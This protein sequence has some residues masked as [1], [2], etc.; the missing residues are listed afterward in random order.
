MTSPE[1]AQYIDT[2]AKRIEFLE[3][4]L[5]KLEKNFNSLFGVVK[6]LSKQNE[7]TT[8]ILVTMTGMLTKE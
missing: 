2:L 5:A 8:G 4:N 3:K 6:L 1:E 7:N